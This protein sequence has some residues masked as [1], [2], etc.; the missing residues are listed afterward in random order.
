[1]KWYKKVFTWIIQ[2]RYPIGILIFAA[3]LRFPGFTF[4]LPTYPDSNEPFIVAY[5]VKM[6]HGQWNPHFFN[7]P[8]LYLYFNAVLVALTHAVYRTL[9]FIGIAEYSYTP[10]WLFFITGRIVNILLSLTAVY[11][12]Y[13]IGSFVFS[14]R[15]GLFGMIVMALMPIL[16]C[17]SIQIAP[18][19]L[20]MV[21]AMGSIYLSLKYL[22]EHNRVFLYWAA[23]CAGLAIGT[24]YMFLAPVSFLLSKY[25]VDKKIKRNF[26]DKHLFLLIG[27][28]IISFC[29]TTPALFVSL[30]EV[31]GHV[32]FEH[33]HYSG[34]G[35]VSISTVGYFLRYL[36][37]H[38]ITPLIFIFSCAGL[39][40]LYV[41]KREECFVL[42]AVPIAWLLF[43]S[44][45]RLASIHNI[46]IIS[47]IFAVGIG[48]ALDSIPQRR[49]VLVVLLLI[50]II[51]II[52]D[53]Q[54]IKMFQKPDIRYHVGDWI[55]ANLPEG[56]V[57]AR[58]EY[59]PY[60]SDKK[61]KSIYLGIC[62]L[63]Y[64][65]PDS[66]R[67]LGCDYI[68]SAGYERFKEN[69]E[70]F[71]Q[72]IANFK[73]HEKEFQTV[74]TFSPEGKYRGEKQIVFKVK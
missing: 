14:K 13:M 63:A 38:G 27:V 73:Q 28:V 45:Y 33:E 39:G 59:T 21:L 49:I 26:W 62:G 19:V 22:A 9:H 8:S 64:I 68:I 6:F 29:I 18:N 7:Y 60:F 15:A 74:K 48:I 2:N 55:D 31:I 52:K 69:P 61:F 51:P 70:L 72:N 4:G 42:L 44:L 34:E 25:F 65:T 5:A 53:I 41:K 1:M 57:V 24:K 11:L 50:S 23:V 66:V 30:P 71:S 54:Q 47:I 12:V 43:C 37:L 46:A 58:E 36:F 67:S 20:F 35:S 17:Y 10:Y 40:I 32:F 3:C 16:Y 56:S